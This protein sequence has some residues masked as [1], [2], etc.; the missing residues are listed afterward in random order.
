MR[1]K[2]HTQDN[3]KETLNTFADID[4]PLL[5]SIFLRAIKHLDRNRLKIEISA[6][7]EGDINSVN[8]SRIIFYYRTCGDENCF[9]E[10]SKFVSYTCELT[11]ASFYM[12][13]KDFKRINKHGLGIA[14]DRNEIRVKYY[15]FLHN[16]AKDDILD[17]LSQD[18]IAG[19][20]P[21]NHNLSEQSIGIIG[22]ETHTRAD[23]CCIK[24][25][26]IRSL[27][28]FYDKLPSEKK[29]Y[30]RAR[31][32]PIFRKKITRW[33]YYVVKFSNKKAVSKGIHILL[34]KDAKKRVQ[35]KFS[36][37]ANIIPTYYGFYFD[38]N[39]TN[40]YHELLYDLRF[41][42]VYPPSQNKCFFPIPPLSLAQIRGYFKERNVLVDLIDL[43][44]LCWDHNIR[45]K[46]KKD[47]INLEFLSQDR[48]PTG[49]TRTKLL[50]AQIISKIIKLGNLD[51][52]P[53][54]GFSIMGIDSLMYS[55]LLARHLKTRF[56]TI[57][58][59][60][61]VYANSFWQELKNYDF[62]DYIV[63]GRAEKKLYELYKSNFRLEDK[64]IKPDKGAFTASQPDF[65][66]LP[67]QI[68]RNAA[69]YNTG[70]PL[71]ILPFELSVGCVY[72]CSFC[73]LANYSDFKMKDATEAVKQIGI[74]MAKYR[75]NLFFFYDSAINIIPSYFKNFVFELRKIRPIKYSCYLFPNIDKESIKL[76]KDSGC[77]NV[78]IAIEDTNQEILDYL[79]KPFKNIPLIK[80]TIVN[81]NKHA[82][83]K[84]QVLFIT[85]I[86]HQAE[87]HVL[88]NAK[89][90]QSIK[91]H[92]SGV[93]VYEYTVHKYS[94]EFSKWDNLKPRLHKG[95]YD[96]E[97]SSEAYLLTVNPETYDYFKKLLQSNGIFVLEPDEN[98]QFENHLM[99]YYGRFY[100]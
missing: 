21:S 45:S 22:I 53:V 13:I 25:Y 30:L 26:S 36:L 65:D 98:K 23:N 42:I 32:H 33:C 40:Y 99:K 80:E 49:K 15:L 100:L 90:L 82:Q 1:P 74:L 28:D 19:N 2:R 75:T 52:Y 47:N 38:S 96:D 71:L 69:K 35:E 85:K 11:K 66:T 16:Q 48:L 39:K 78:R 44:A 92:I 70:K 93:S 10:W 50:T 73:T 12:D 14:V 54:L 94:N 77:I 64:V 18:I 62:I 57:I 86:P 87:Q 95:L 76:L 68:Y 63:C 56:D 83:L 24:I 4:N 7:A 51:K 60:G 58:V 79:N 27:K 20:I 6:Q 29:G 9:R 17:L 41:G 55:L 84:T 3:P 31:L 72:N 59:F 89:F 81:L 46:S 97:F 67:L 91:E 43:E 88:K 8:D 5:N 37:K 34:N 61:G